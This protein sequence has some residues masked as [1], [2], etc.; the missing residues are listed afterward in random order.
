MGRSC[1]HASTAALETDDVVEL[2]ASLTSLLNDNLKMYEA[3]DADV[4]DEAVRNA[5]VNRP[6][7]RRG[8]S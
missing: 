1:A 4:V 5:G 8:G 2:K 7:G 6:W 3:V